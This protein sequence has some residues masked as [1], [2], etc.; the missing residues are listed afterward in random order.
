MDSTKGNTE[1][2]ALVKLIDEPDD[3]IYSKILERIF[4]YGIEAV[5][6]LE[7]AWENNF[8]PEVQQRLE[9]II[10]KLQFSNI[11]NELKNWV[12]LEGKN[13]FLGFSIITRYQYPDLDASYYKTQLDEIGKRIWIELNDQLT[14]IEKIVKVFNR[15]FFQE[16]GFKGNR[17][18]YQ[19]PLNSYL[20]NVIDSKTGNPLSLSIIYMIIARDMGLPVYGVN[21]PE[22]FILAYADELYSPFSDEEP[23]IM[24]YINPLSNGAIFTRNEIDDF[25]IIIETEPLQMYYNPC[26]HIDIMIRLIRNLITAYTL[27]RNKQKLPELQVLLSI[28]SEKK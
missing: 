11:C 9:W 4:F 28:L 23:E 8:N 24:F 6:F 2:D 5:P 7:K 19:Y 3:L 16:L 22:Y 18:Q 25:L 12:S 27:A 13:L 17:D 15:I 21:L 26:S 20:N 14:A 10:H 1:L